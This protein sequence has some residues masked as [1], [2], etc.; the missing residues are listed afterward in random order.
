M[1]IKRTAL[2]KKLF[3]DPLLYISL[4]FLIYPS[5][6]YVGNFLS[7]GAE[8]LTWFI[9]TLGFNLCLRNTGIVS[10]GHGAFFG[11]GSYATALSYLHIFGKD[12]FVMPIILGAITGTL[13]AAFL[14][15][16]I[17]N[18]KGIYYALL[19]VVFTEVLYV[20]CWKWTE[21][22][23]G[24]AGLKDIVRTSF[25]GIDMTDPTK[26]Y[27]FIFIIFVISAVVIRMIAE[28]NFGKS[29]Q[30]VKS[31]PVRSEALGYNV[32]FY[33]FAVFT[34]SGFWAGLGGALY[35]F[36]TQSVFASMLNWMKSG[37][38]LMATVLGGGLSSFY[39]PILGS[40]I[41]LVSQELVSGFWVH[42]R[43]IFGLAF[44]VIVLI[45][46]T[47]LLGNVKKG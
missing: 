24:E 19:T 23:G 7:F 28:S 44:V 46:P 37:D 33:K 16:F 26:Y 17:R 45:L 20:I 8:L 41:F 32:G 14:G 30:A 38:A 40:A 42:W 12:S 47:G 34:I 36:I 27:Y 6:P 18:K 21:V 10:F 22:T 2:M 13:F 43:L 4:L 11:V 15:F 1:M 9:F 3:H 29:L 35:C 31:N 39:G 25:W 5:L